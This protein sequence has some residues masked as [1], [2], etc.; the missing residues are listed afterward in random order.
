MRIYF[1][2]NGLGFG[3]VSRDVQLA[4]EL[5]KRGHEIIFSTYGD[6]IRFLKNYNFEVI[7]VEEFGEV[8]FTS[9]EVEL[10]KSIVKTIKSVSPSILM[11]QRKILKD[12]SP[13][14]MVVDGYIPAMVSRIFSS[15]KNMQ[16]YLITNE[17]IQWKRLGGNLPVKKIAEF[18]EA[19]LVYL[20]DRVII[21]DFPP[22]YT[23][24]LENLGFFDQKEKFHFVG[25]IVRDIPDTDN[26]KNIVVSFG[27]SKV[28]ADVTEVLKR[29]EEILGE[30]FVYGYEL[31]HE[32]YLNRLREAKLLIT[33]GGHNSI[34]EALAFGK[35]V[36]GIPIKNYP[37]R[38]GNLAGVE[39]LRLGRVMDVDW[40]NEQVLA[41]AVEEV[42]GEEYHTRAKVLSKLARAMPG[43]DKAVALIENGRM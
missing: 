10:Y 18:S 2:S 28:R 22:P 34:M 41:T 37:E 15:W 16:L 35:P 6:G 14:L 12:I 40:L 42:S 30:K 24:C 25:P 21:P 5:E 32:D 27:G 8:S 31:K 4:L 39:R 23:V 1:V 26:R 33:H 36:V 29:T 9:R 19:L 7:E 11:D 43:I 3:H 13:D 38:Q 20:A 17:T